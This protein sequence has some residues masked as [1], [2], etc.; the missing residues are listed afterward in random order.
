M[1]GGDMRMRMHPMH[2]HLA[3]VLLCSSWLPLCVTEVVA[4][5]DDAIWEALQA[6]GKVLLLR[7]ARIERDEGSADPRVRDPSCRAEAKLS[8]QG[9]QD[10]AELGRRFRAQQVPVSRVRH[11]PYCRTADTAVIAFTQA[12]PAAFL[13]LIEGLPPDAAAEQTAQLQQVISAYAED[14][15]LILVTHRP[16]IAAVS[17]ELLGHLDA[18][19]LAPDGAGGFDELGVLRFSSSD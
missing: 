2:H 17:F 19:V 15:V 6:G 4:D 10:A 3:L 14:G 5:T 11:S 18:L 16:N 7:H 13:S 1:R 8:A 12:S 9:R